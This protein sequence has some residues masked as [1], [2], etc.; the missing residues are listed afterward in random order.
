MRYF[1]RERESGNSARMKI[2]VPGATIIPILDQNG[3]GATMNELSAHWGQ[4]KENCH[5][6]G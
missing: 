1:D 6:K 4:G 2:S 3:T 5:D